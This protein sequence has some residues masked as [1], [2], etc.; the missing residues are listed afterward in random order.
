MSEAADATIREANRQD[1]DAVVALW[2]QLM[3]FHHELDRSRWI[4]SEDGRREYRN[5]MLETLAE[6]DRVLFVA[7]ERKAIVGFT[8]GLLKPGPPM[9]APKRVGSVSDLMVGPDHRGEG[10]GSRLIRA[11]V[12]WFRTHGADEVAVNVAA[13]NPH[14]KRFWQ[15]MGFEP[16]TERMCKVL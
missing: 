15:A 2:A 1:L 11:I 12:E 3:A 5:W 16:W 13:R 10:V 14:A 7:D 6:P 8:H 9:F 4:L